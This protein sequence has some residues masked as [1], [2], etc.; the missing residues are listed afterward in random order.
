MISGMADLLIRNVPVETLA[1]IKE[2]AKRHRRSVQAEVLAALT[3]G[4]RPT[5]PDLVAWL[6]TIRP[7]NAT[8]ADIDAGT[9][10][11]REDRDTR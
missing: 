4:A 2:R 7:P 6:K 11:I 3:L 9:A 8:R 5:G 1:A 10:A